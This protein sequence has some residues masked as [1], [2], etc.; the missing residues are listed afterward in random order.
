MEFSL[1]EL[2]YIKRLVR[3]DVNRTHTD[4]S[5]FK[6]KLRVDRKFIDELRLK[7]EEIKAIP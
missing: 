2:R 7:T 6:F 3:N 1:K 4:D 5:E